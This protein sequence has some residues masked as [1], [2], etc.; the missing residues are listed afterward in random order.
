[1]TF[2]ERKREGFMN[3]DDQTV[4]TL[5]SINF[6]HKEGDGSLGIGAELK[7]QLSNLREG[8]LR[9]TLFVI[10]VINLSA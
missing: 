10:K 7:K 8:I 1:L 3:E 2:T 4:N 5:G 9:K 6:K